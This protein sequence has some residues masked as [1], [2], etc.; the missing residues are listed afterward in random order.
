MARTTVFVGGR[1]QIINVQ[2]LDAWIEFNGATEDPSAAAANK[3]LFSRNG[4]LP[5]INPNTITYDEMKGLPNI[6]NVLAKKLIAQQ[7]FSSLSAARAVF[8]DSWAG[9]L[10]W[11]EK[12]VPTV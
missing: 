10:I 9:N 6:G 11:E 7:P 12:Q 4:D 2:D 8:P 3:T 5:L 1:A